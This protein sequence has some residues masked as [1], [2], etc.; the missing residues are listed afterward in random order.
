MLDL[1]EAFHTVDHNC[2]LYK[3]KNKFRITGNALQWLSSYLSNRSSLVVLNGCYSTN[4]I[5]TFGVRQGSV[6][7]PLLFILYTNELSDVYKKFNLKMHSYADDTILYLDFNPLSE[8]NTVLG[9][10]QKCLR[11]IETWMSQNLLKLKLHKTPLLVC[12]KKR[13]LKFY[14]VDIENIN[15]DLKIDCSLMTSA[16][17]LQHMITET[18]KICFFKLLKLRNFRVF[19]SQKHKIMLIKSFIILR[20]DYCNCLYACIPHYLL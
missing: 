8:F 10:L 17:P 11:K 19:L 5:Y 18:C 4:K 2:L 13:L 7:G 15:I 12:G 9:T 16:K 14:Q 6:L 20:L 3:L 1:S